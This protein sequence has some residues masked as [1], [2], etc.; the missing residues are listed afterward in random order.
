MMTHE[1]E[2]L[3]AR[4]AARKLGIPYQWLL[5]EAKRGAIPHLRAKRMILFNLETVRDHL[6]EREL[7]AIGGE[8]R[9]AG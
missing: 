4:G 2:Y 5:D 8:V 1:P 3:S 7:A 6:R 9:N